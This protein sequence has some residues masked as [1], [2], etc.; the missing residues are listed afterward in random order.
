M[1]CSRDVRACQPPADSVGVPALEPGWAA[2]RKHRVRIC[3][4]CRNSFVR[5]DG[6][7]PKCERK[8]ADR[9][10][11]EPERFADKFLDGAY[12]GW[13]MSALAPGMARVKD[14]KLR[15][16]A[17]PYLTDTAQ[18]DELARDDD[19][20][21]R[22]EVAANPYTSREALTWLLSGSEER[23]YRNA[24]ANPSLPLEALDHEARQAEA[25]WVAVFQ[26]ALYQ[27]SMGASVAMMASR[28][29][30]ISILPLVI[31]GMYGR[32]LWQSWRR[33]LTLQRALRRRQRSSQGHLN[34]EAGEQGSRGGT[35]SLHPHPPAPLRRNSPTHRS[36]WGEDEWLLVREELKL[37]DLT[38]RDHP[39]FYGDGITGEDVSRIRQQGIQSDRDAEVMG[40]VLR[41][42]KQNALDMPGWYGNDVGPGDFERMEE[43]LRCPG[44]G[45]PAG[46]THRC[47]GSAS[48]REM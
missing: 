42:M 3:S 16:K 31:T 25:R 34:E 47:H 48:S 18:L 23:I 1:S 5:A 46:P 7:C 33:H 20:G 26:K 19:A 36:L 17:V 21:V 13:V 37:M 43:T 29:G 39:D 45:R 22:A 2:G 35:S 40:K 10:I 4:I 6:S 38:L 41:I 8:L 12:P 30:R 32:A 28:G 27:F 11:R 15:R 14:A 44:C 24:A 9:A